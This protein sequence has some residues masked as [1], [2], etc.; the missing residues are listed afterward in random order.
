MGDP[1]WG[2]LTD[3][4]GRNRW[5]SSIRGVPRRILIALALV[6]AAV[7]PAA[8][9]AGTTQ[10][11]DRLGGAPC[12]ASSAFTCVSIMVPLDH[13]APADERLIRVWFA[14][15]P[16]TGRRDGILAVATGGPGSSGILS[17]DSYLSSYS[18]E[19]LAH[20]DLVFFDQRG[21]GR[22]GGNTCPEAVA[23]SR[24][25]ADELVPATEQFVRACVAELRRPGL[26]PYVGTNQAVEDLELFRRTLGGRM[27][28]YGESYGT[29]YAQTYAAAHPKAL[30][31]VVIDGVVDLTL[32]GPDFWRSAARQFESVLDTTLRICANRP[33]CKADAGGDPEALYDRVLARVQDAPIDVRFPLPGG[34]RVDRE[35]TESL[36]QTA[37][38]GELYGTN[39]RMMLTRALVAAARDDYV[40]LLRLAYQDA[41]LDEVTLAPEVDPAWSDAMYLGVDCRDYGYYAGTPAERAAQWVADADVVNRQLPRIG[42]SIF[43]GDFPCVD[44]PGASTSQVR[45]APLRNP[46]IP[47]FVITATGD[48]IT[49]A[50]QGRAVWSRLD[51]GYLITTTGGPHVTFGRG[52][53]CPDDVVM[54]FLE[55]GATPA[56]REIACP[57][58][59]V[60]DYQPLAPATARA[61]GSP[62]DA[63]VSFERQLRRLP[64]YWYW[65]GQEARATACPVAGSVRFRATG[66][67][68]AFTF[69]GCSF[70][71][72][73]AFTGTG[74][75]TGDAFTLTGRLAGRWRGP[76]DFAHAGRAIDLTW[77]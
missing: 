56:K 18:A 76:L 48:P 17:A 14:V 70:T 2:R 67:G 9:H 12:S 32:S 34:R 29:Q 10:T 3:G 40:P 68:T 30:Q 63:L 4:T 74:A 5:R 73:V 41:M 27:I 53:P 52:E 75:D 69:A 45:P 59:Y 6:A 16:A 20:R 65:D 47:T 37:V 25:S 61:F 36:F 43:L 26:L 28:L 50:T 46:G 38:S 72:G 13:F 77:S 11:L 55:T 54:R 21:I 33:A 1:T 66:D 57:G 31:G 60:R 51:D 64:E 35:L 62:E 58:V 39:G 15:R 24:T 42:G 22:S 8:A 49:P 19:V 44:W 71:K 7:F 23:E